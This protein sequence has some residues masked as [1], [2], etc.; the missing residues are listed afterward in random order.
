MVYSYINLRPYGVFKQPFSSYSFKRDK[1]FDG[2]PKQ[3]RLAK[4]SSKLSAAK[5]DGCVK[6][7]LGQLIIRRWALED[8]IFSVIQSHFVVNVSGLSPWG[9]ISKVKKPVRFQ[10][11]LESLWFHFK[12]KSTETSQ[13]ISSRMLNRALFALW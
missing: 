9:G 8:H 1:C 4:F 3:A 12:I 7:I 2:W 5:K 10:R 6:Q 13:H 11:M